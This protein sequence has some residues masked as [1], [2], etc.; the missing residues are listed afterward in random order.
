MIPFFWIYNT[1][2][3]FVDCSST[4]LKKPWGQSY[5]VFKENGMRICGVEMK[6]AYGDGTIKSFW[7]S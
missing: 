2:E 5:I 6:N 1:T 7:L 4:I 3:Y